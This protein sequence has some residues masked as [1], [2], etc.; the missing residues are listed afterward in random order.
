MQHEVSL[1][2]A[3]MR[4]I[5]LA[6]GLLAL[7]LPAP[8][9]AQDGLDA[10]IRRTPHGIPHIEAKDY[11][12]L[13]YGYGYALAEDNLCTIADQYVT[14]RGE[15]SRFFGPDAT[16]TWRGNSSVNT[17]SRPTSSSSGSST[18][19][20]SRGSSTK[21][22]PNGPRPEVQASVVRGYVAGYNRYLRDTGVDEPARPRLPRPGVGA[23]DRGDRRL[24]AL[25]P[26]RAARL[27]GRRDRRRRERAA[28]DAGH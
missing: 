27:D 3:R 4:R 8:A 2:C 20:S 18:R 25:L 23:P 14:V 1:V 22:P 11:A 19:A 15:R 28:A 13:G 26:A 16:Y 10:T 6:A 12:G 9:A 17:T 5:A 21:A 7:L 24:P